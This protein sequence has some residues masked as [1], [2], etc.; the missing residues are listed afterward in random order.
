MAEIWYQIIQ[1]ET[2]SQSIDNDFG[3]DFDLKKA[4]PTLW[5]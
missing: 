5:T 2:V 1:I 3:N 4:T